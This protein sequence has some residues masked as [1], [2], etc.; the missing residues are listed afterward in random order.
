MR[1]HILTSA[2]AVLAL[3]ALAVTTAPAGAP[4]TPAPPL[5]VIAGPNS[6][7]GAREEFV[8]GPGRLGEVY[9]LYIEVPPGQP[10]L[11]IDVFDANTGDGDT[12]DGNDELESDAGRDHSIGGFDGTPSTTTYTVIDPFGATVAAPAIGNTVGTDQ[13]DWSTIYTVSSP[14]AGHWLV[15]IDMTGDDYNAFAVRAHDGDPGPGGIENNVYWERFVPTGTTGVLGTPSPRTFTLHP[16]VTEGCDLRFFDWDADNNQVQLDIALTNRNGFFSQPVSDLGFAAPFSPNG[17]WGAL[18]FVGWADAGSP[19]AGIGS[20]GYG[21]WVYEMTAR[22]YSSTRSNMITSM[23]GVSGGV[24]PTPPGAG[25][26]FTAPTAEDTFRVYLPSDNGSAPPL[27]WVSHTVRNFG[28]TF[29][30]PPAPGETGTLL[31]RITV[32]N[33]NQTYPI[34]FDTIQGLEV[35]ADIPGGLVVSDGPANATAS[36]G[37][38][39][40]PP[41]GSGGL[42]EWDPG[43][44]AGGSTATLDYSITV[45]PLPSGTTTLSGP[46]PTTATFLDHTGNFQQPQAI[47]DFGP[48]CEISVTTGEPLLVKLTDFA[49]TYEN[50]GDPV[51]VTWTTAAELDT[52]TFDVY[53]VIAE[54][55]EGMVLSQVNED[56]IPAQG[57]PVAGANYAFQDANPMGDGEERSYV[58]IE[59]ELSGK[60]N[61]YGPVTATSSKG[62]PTAVQDWLNHR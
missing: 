62:T 33:P 24:T 53:E 58:L 26:A 39:T 51:D 5:F 44:V 29:S 1:P 6:P 49:A 20:G 27:P 23:F 40:V 41:A 35:I 48:L 22:L 4:I 38:F 56:P 16:Y 28:P 61:T 32:N 43:V 42:V 60:T 14:A 47:I 8:I 19:G 46:Q 55:G 50:P 25:G 52:M 37:T 34:V 9:Q 30:N 57:S 10:N 45:G 7:T 11:F 31:L 21:A 12:T 2:S 18:S 13:N 59:T 15:E 54:N 36:Q 17:R 3:S